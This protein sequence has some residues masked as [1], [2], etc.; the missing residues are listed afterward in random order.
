MGSNYLNLL[1]TI[2][3]EIAHLSLWQKDQMQT[4]L[5]WSTVVNRNFRVVVVVSNNF[6]P[7]THCI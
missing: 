6:Q 4:V 5:S 1:D 7:S 2:L 3:D